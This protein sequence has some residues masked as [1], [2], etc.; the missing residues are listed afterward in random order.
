[1]SANG[2]A[3]TAP[4]AASAP[5]SATAQ[6]LRPVLRY[7]VGS[8]IIIGLA[9]ILGHELAYIIPLLALNFLAPGN[10]LPT[11]F[12]GLTFLAIV[13]IT[14]TAGFL[15]VK[16]FYDHTWF[17]LPVLALIL[18]WIYYTTKLVISVKL[19]LLISFLAM[20]VPMYHMDPTTW[21]LALQKT[22]V[23][24][25][26]FT[27]LMVLFVYVLFPDKPGTAA[28][29]TPQGA[30]GLSREMRLSRALDIFLVTFPVVVLYI[31]FQWGNSLLI[32]LYV[33]VLSMMPSGHKAGM[34]KLAGNILGGGITLIFYQLITIVPNFFFFLLVYLGLALFFANKIF[35]DTRALLLY[36]T[37]FSTI[38]LIMSESI[39]GGEEAGTAIGI[40]I[41]EVFGVVVY[42]ITSFALLNL[43]KTQRQ[44]RK[45][46]RKNIKQAVSQGIK[47]KSK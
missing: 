40:R 36:K 1:M 38:T 16:Y 44:Y 12:G 34:A 23:Y 5:A 30:A 11:T 6:T 15:F 47:R 35:S 31:F 18:F 7:A 13:V 39:L 28:A 37:A 46:R 25:S 21:A 20:P 42:I 45:N 22:L 8:T 17:F 14:T 3:I 9:V 33:V 29:V 32:L 19:F 41:L 24:G 43:I 27:L 2:S 10:K 4:S 26:F